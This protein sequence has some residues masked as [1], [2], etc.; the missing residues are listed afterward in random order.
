VKTIGNLLW[1]VLSGFWMAIGYL[2]AGALCCLTVSG[3]PFGLASFRL[4]GYA[5]WPFGRTVVPNPDRV[6]G[7][8]A[9]GNVIWFLLGGWWLALGHL[10]T[11]CLLCLTI[12]GIPFGIAGF[13]MAGLALTPLG[14]R[15]VPA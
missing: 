14:H 2:V 3:I 12:I 5:L 4:A 10:L 8:S 6:P 9:V 15:I 1:L 11:G 13:K 7:V